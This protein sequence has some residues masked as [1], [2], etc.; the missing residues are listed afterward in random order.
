M[1]TKKTELNKEEANYSVIY[2]SKLLNKEFDSLE[3]LKTAEDNFKSNE[4][5]KEEA[6]A[7][8]KS[9]AA[10][11]QKAW[12]EKLA[13]EKARNAKVLE[14]GNVR[15]KAVAE[16]NKKY[17]EEIVEVEK[18]LKAAQEK[19]AAALKTFQE[20]HPEGYHLT[21]KDGDNTTTLQYNVVGGDVMK[22]VMKDAL[23]DFNTTFSL[24]SDF[25]K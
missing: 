20:A 22:D 8:R 24:F 2:K 4:K 13:A 19:Y 21:L 1:M 6:K 16:A 23:K 15:R 18:Q 5:K 7:L 14:A 11:V 17:Y 25:W 9:D 10:V 12:E 3:E